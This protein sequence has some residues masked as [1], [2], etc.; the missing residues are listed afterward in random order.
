MGSIGNAVSL[1]HCL[2]P[3]LN[4]GHQGKSTHDSI[5]LEGKPLHNISTV[6]TSTTS[7][8]C[9]L[10]LSWAVV[11]RAYVG[12]DSICFYDTSCKGNEKSPHCDDSA[13]LDFELSGAETVSQ[14]AQDLDLR[15]QHRAHAAVS[16]SLKKAQNREAFSRANTIFTLRNHNSQT[17]AKSAGSAYI[18]EVSFS[19]APK[20]H[21][22]NDKPG[23]FNTRC[24][25]S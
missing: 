23:S 2:F 5:R 3:T 8:E 12:V 22:P 9:L 11:L 15:F 20:R 4:D 21:H 14:C 24:C 10:R 6:Q 1:P 16:E 13:L 17:N 19:K 25:H 7:L 18:S